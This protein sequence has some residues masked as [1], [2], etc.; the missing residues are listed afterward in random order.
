MEFTEEQK[1][2]ALKA[3]A[4]LDI[5]KP[6]INKFDKKGVVTMFEGFAGFYIDETTNGGEIFKKIKEIQEKRGYLVYA[7]THEMT[8]IGEMYDLLVIPKEDNEDMVQEL[9]NNHLVFAYVW[10]RTDDLCSEAGDIVVQSSGGGIR[11][12][13]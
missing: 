8:N 9:G 12:I 2:L 11:R 1:T 4:T 13:K 6:Y 3:L 7:V 10:N 5:Y